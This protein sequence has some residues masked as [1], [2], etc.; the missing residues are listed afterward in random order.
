[1]AVHLLLEER[2]GGLTSKQ[3]ELLIAARDDSDRLNQIIENLLDMGRME[4]GRVGMD[5]RP[6]PADQVVR[7]AVEPA[8]AAYQDKGVEL[9][10]DVPAD[11]PDV[12]ADDTRVG[13]VLS[14][15]L[16][17]A[18]RYTPPGGRV[19]VAATVEPGFVRFTVEDTGP[20]IP[21]QYQGRVF[22]RF[23]RAPGQSGGTGAGLG[24]AIAREIVGAHGGSIGVD[25]AEGG[26]ARFSFTLPR[27]D[28]PPASPA[29]PERAR[30]ALGLHG[31]AGAGNG[32][33]RDP[34]PR[35]AL[36]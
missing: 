28:R 12:M 6:V 9:D 27:A 33:A 31:G 2:V 5:L 11:A 14:N 25:G 3:Q 22:E 24:L 29:T 17:N 30:P 20:G 36:S 19:R 21:S 35:G 1:M 4:S 34:S 23:F 10:A 26:G 18:L 15:L 7:E 8:A 32:A 16:S 13:H